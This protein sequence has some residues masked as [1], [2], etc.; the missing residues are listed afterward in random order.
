MTLYRRVSPPPVRRSG[1]W[2][3]G[4]RWCRMAE[5]GAWLLVQRGACGAVVHGA[6]VHGAGWYMLA[7]SIAIL[8]FG[9]FMII[10]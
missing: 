10:G 7:R 3:A 8:E 4:C 9:D 1:R 2:L 6:V 5:H